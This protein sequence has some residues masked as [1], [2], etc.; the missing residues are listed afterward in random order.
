M[1]RRGWGE[2]GGEKGVGRRRWGEGGGEKGVGR[3]GW[4]EGGGG[5]GVGGRGW[6]EPG[7]L[8]GQTFDKVGVILTQQSLCTGCSMLS[9][10][11]AKMKNI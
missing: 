5:K 2:G 9:Y 8:G 7:H 3:R 11:D 6:G 1:G 10:P 4:G